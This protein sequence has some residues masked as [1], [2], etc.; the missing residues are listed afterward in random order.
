MTESCD[1]CQLLDKDRTLIKCSAQ[2]CSVQ[3]AFEAKSK[4]RFAAACINSLQILQWKLLSMLCFH[5]YDRLT[6]DD[7]DL[8]R[9]P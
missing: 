6:R 7:Y 3:H 1:E 4:K 9:V 2:N 8:I 5:L